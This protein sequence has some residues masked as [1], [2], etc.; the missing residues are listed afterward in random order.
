MRRVRKEKYSI[1]NHRAVSETV[2]LKMLREDGKSVLIQSKYPQTNDPFNNVAQLFVFRYKVSL[3]TDRSQSEAKIFLRVAFDGLI[4][5]EKLQ[6][7]YSWL[8]FPGGACSEKY[9][10]QCW[11]HK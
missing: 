4:E 11:R 6:Q 7:S 2:S 9:T 5:V 8:G 1:S 10:C 3:E